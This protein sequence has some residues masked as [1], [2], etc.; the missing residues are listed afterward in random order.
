MRG[1][2]APVLADAGVRRDLRA[3]ATSRFDGPSLVRDTEA[4]ARFG[5]PALVLWSPDNVVMPPAHGRR[6]AALMPSARYAEVPG[7][8]VLSQLDEPGLV[9]PE[10]GGFLASSNS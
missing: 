8:L 6:L 10:I 4:L 3:Y 1:W 9:V 2:T 5:G 7:A